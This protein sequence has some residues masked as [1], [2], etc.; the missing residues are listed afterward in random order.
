[1]S[2][3]NVKQMFGKMEKDSALKD[4]YAQLVQ[5]HQNESEKKLTEKLVELGQTSGFVFSKD[6]LVAARAELI[7]NANSNGELADGDLAK[8]AGGG[9]LSK[10]VAIYGSVITLGVMCAVYSVI[11]EVQNPGQCK[12]DMSV[13]CH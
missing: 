7:D 11:S 2:K 6:D 8:V 10:S 13:K 1:M 9:R 5:S 3:D 12:D 4:K